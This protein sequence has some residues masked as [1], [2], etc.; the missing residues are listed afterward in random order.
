MSE[1]MTQQ[2]FELRGNIY[3]NTSSFIKHPWEDTQ[4]EVNIACLWGELG[5]GNLGSKEAV[6]YVLLMHI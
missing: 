2:Y 5:G 1:L 3:L 6:L 4:A